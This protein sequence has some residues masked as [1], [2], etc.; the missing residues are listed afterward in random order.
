MTKEKEKELIRRINNIESELDHVGSLDRRF[1]LVQTEWHKYERAYKAYIAR[2]Y[3][4][5][6]WLYKFYYRLRYRRIPD[7]EQMTARR[8]A[9]VFAKGVD[10]EDWKD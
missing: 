9:R 8:M 4:I 5:R 2:Q 3:R 7:V 10:K 1:A 6:D